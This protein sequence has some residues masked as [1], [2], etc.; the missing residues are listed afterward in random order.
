VAGL[1]NITQDHLDYH[2]TM[3]RY[4]AAKAILFRDLL[5]PESGVAVL[6]ADDQAGLAMR[7]EV[8]GPVLT[9]SGQPRGADVAV[10]DRQLGI[11][12][13][14]VKLATPRGR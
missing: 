1:S 6:F 5:S 13:T 11:D 8:R 9:L 12:G 3:E 7:R 4:R 14:R 10:L 2:G